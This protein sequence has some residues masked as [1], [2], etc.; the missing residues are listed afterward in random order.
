MNVCLYTPRH[1]VYSLYFVGY[2]FTPST[3]YLTLTLI[4]NQPTKPQ[5]FLN[6]ELMLF[7]YNMRSYCQSTEHK[8]V[9]GKTGRLGIGIMYPGGLLFCEL[10]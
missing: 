2:L 1:I 9:K 5:N 3:A 10:A 8:G 4:N 6:H 7:Y